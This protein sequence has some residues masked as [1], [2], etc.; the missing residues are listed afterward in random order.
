MYIS[1]V[2]PAFRY[3]CLADD[4]FVHRMTGREEVKEESDNT[5]DDLGERVIGWLIYMHTTELYNL[6]RYLE[7]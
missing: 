2:L 3:G 4:A 1:V 6:C 5:T 7:V